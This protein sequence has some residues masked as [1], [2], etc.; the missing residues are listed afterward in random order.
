MDLE[1]QTLHY[2]LKVFSFSLI[3]IF[4]VFFL[5]ILGIFNKNLSLK[6]NPISISKGERVEQIIT[7]NINNLSFLDIKMVKI[8]LIINKFINKKF[9]HYGEFKINNEVTLFDLINII[10]M[11]S[12]L[13]DKITI[14]EGWTKKQLNAELSKYFKSYK[15]VPY[16]EIIADTYFIQKNSDFNT[17]MNKL[18]KIK[19]N[20]FIEYR[21]NKILNNFNENEIMVIGSLLEKEGLG[22]NDKKNISSV[23]FNRLDKKMKLQ[24]DATVLF[25]ITNGDY[26]LGRK[27]LL[28]D[29]KIDHP[30][31]TYINWGLPPKPISYVGRKTL[32]IIFEKKETEFLFYFFNKSLNKHIFSKTYKEHIEKLNEYRNK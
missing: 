30:Y 15:S 28:N 16:N 14:V 13:Y 21:N 20:Y 4:L 17:F 11:P 3:I 32:D 27:L 5:Y 9:I 2:Y 10:T 23:I 8:Y 26:D 19:T 31:N 24:I 12:N 6:T 1:E 22:I 18:N 7:S 29:L 25:A